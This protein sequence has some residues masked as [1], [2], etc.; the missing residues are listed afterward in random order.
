MC[1]FQQVFTHFVAEL[2]VCFYYKNFKFVKCKIDLS[3]LRF[4]RKLCN[5][6]DADKQFETKLKSSRNHL[7]TGQHLIEIQVCKMI[8]CLLHLGH[9]MRVI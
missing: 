7:M 2:W 5:L 8:S 3:N 6:C 9:L 1:C 4:V